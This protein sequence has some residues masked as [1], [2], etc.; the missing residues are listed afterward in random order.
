MAPAPTLT[1]VSPSRPPAAAPAGRGAVKIVYPAAPGSF[2]ELS[3]K[4][5]PAVVNIRTTQV[6][7]GGPWEYWY[8]DPFGGP[9]RSPS[10]GPG[11]KSLGT[12]FLVDEDGMVLTNNHVIANAD[13]IMVQTHDKREFRAKLVGRDEKTDV[14]LLRIERT[15]ITPL[16]LGDSDAA[17]VGEWVVAVGEPFGLSHTVTAGIVSA[18]GRDDDEMQGFGREGYWNF[19]QT[20]AS[21]NPG[22]SGGPLVNLSGE[23]IGMNTA[24][25]AQ[26]TGI[27]FAVPANMIRDI[28]PHLKREGR[29]TRSWL[30]VMIQEITPQL[31]AHLKLARD[32]GVLI[33]EVIEG[34]PAERA[35]LRPGDLVLEFNGKPIQS[36]RELRWQA[37][38]AGVG[39]DV[40]LRIARGQSE[41]V[42]T[43]RTEELPQPAE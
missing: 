18:K 7:R 8:G 37:S 24:I 14:A 5:V 6:V 1:P 11:K 22:N 23:V 34:G 12:G 10:E 43:L 36:R 39:R 25:R 4:V 19:I 15:G 2:V 35:G 17:E 20:D 30:G 32:R 21:I 16:R 40:P 13:V 29:V 3:R 26:A 42:L 27:G 31:K 41:Y 38:L 33:T 9:R 28:L